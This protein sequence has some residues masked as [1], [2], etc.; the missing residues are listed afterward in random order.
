MEARGKQLGALGFCAFS[1]PAVLILPSVGWLWAGI[2]SVL[3]A[4]LLGLLLHL[5]RNHEGSLAQMSGKT[6]LGKGLLVLL[7]LWNLFALGSAARQ[8]CG[9]FPTAQQTPLIGLLLLLAAAYAA[10]KKLAPVVAALCLFFLLGLYGLLFGFSL[11]NMR[12][13]YLK[14]VSTVPWEKLTAVLAPLSVIYLC[15][16]EKKGR[17]T[18]WLLGGVVFAVLAAL[19]TVGSLSPA[20]TA[21]ST[22]PF[23]EAAKS[24]TVLGA[25]QRLEPL[26]SAGLCAG[27]FCLL[28]LVCSANG[29]LL[30]G[31]CPGTE[32]F[33]GLINFL[34]GGGCLWLSGLSSGAFVAAGTT[35]FWGIFPFILL[36]LGKQKNIKN[37]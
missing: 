1:V 8:L 30:H 7:L 35:I 12:P 18:W 25:I 28:S 24:V 14:P 23:Y 2:A 29:E 10:G 22:F 26:V 21:K 11:P 27:G 15:R 19:V 6:P 31:I 13:E 3:G 20:E 9:I 37:F 17:P 33:S 32:K 36:V 5:S 4:V 16:G 34:A